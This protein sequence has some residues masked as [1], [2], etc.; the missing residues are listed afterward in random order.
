MIEV[1]QHQGGN[2]INKTPE[3]SGSRIIDAANF[4]IFG[5]E[6]MGSL[7][8]SNIIEVGV[9][10]DL[11]SNGENSDL[12]FGVQAIS[13]SG[14]LENPYLVIAIQGDKKIAKLIDEIDYEDMPPWQ[15]AMD[16]LPVKE[17]LVDL[18]KWELLDRL[19]IYAWQQVSE[20]FAVA[21][22]SSEVMG[23]QGEEHSPLRGYLY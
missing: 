23:A 11:R 21:A 19:Y 7:S 18:A 2:K 20:I 10:A 4:H 13:L 15:A 9:C 5:E 3:V 6:I 14:D 16:G 22:D 12:L 8:Q 17:D 1:L